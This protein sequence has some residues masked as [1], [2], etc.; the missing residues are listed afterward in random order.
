MRTRERPSTESTSLELGCNNTIS[1]TLTPAEGKPAQY[2]Y[3]SNK[4]VPFQTSHGRCVIEFTGRK[5][6]GKGNIRP[7][8]KSL[9]TDCDCDIPKY[10]P[11]FMLTGKIHKYCKRISDL[12]IL[13]RFRTLIDTNIS[14]AMAT[15]LD[16][17]LTAIRPGATKPDQDALAN[18]KSWLE[19][20]LS[21]VVWSL[22]HC[23]N[24]DPNWKTRDYVKVADIE[25]LGTTNVATTPLCYDR[26][27]C[28]HDAG[29]V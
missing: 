1:T 18:A 14:D 8:L 20:C 15:R 6:C 19:I 21:A 24:V 23:E 17:T 3:G 25:I 11:Q 13:E 5:G 10:D 27:R 16:L 12:L 22:D 29:H 28:I 4:F 9:L 7:S 2:L 26:Q